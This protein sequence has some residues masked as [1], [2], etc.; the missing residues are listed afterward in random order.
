MNDEQARAALC[1]A[2]EKAFG[3][4]MEK[5]SDFDR[6][7]EYIF[8]KTH[9]KVSTTT[10][11]RLWGYLK[12]GNSP[13]ESTLDILAQSLGETDWNT[14]CKKRNT[15]DKA[16]NDEPLKSVNRWGIS[17]NHDSQR[18]HLF[19]L[20][21]L[22]IVAAGLAYWFISHR[23]ATDQ[24]AANAHIL[25]IGDKFATYE[26]YLQLFGVTECELP[27]TVPVPHHTNMILFGGQYKNPTWGNEGDSAK[28]LPTFTYSYR[29][30]DVPP[31]VVASR[32]AEHYQLQRES[33]RL[34]ITFMKDLVDTNFVFIGVYRMSLSRS[35]STQITWERVA[36]EVNIAHLEYLEL[37]RN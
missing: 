4:K 13:R 8:E 23:N 18:R 25:R 34:A 30:S 9:E 12:E 24:K 36:E 11:K 2:L 21:P 22:A 14:F 31:E 37:L 35:D 17:Q 28:L 15:T 32:N 20:I 5:A 1:E 33:N 7:S 16:E 26:D 10:L 19:Y 3:R 29:N 27:Y 6:L